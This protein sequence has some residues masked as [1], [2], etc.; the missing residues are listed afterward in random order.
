MSSLPV[1]T[2]RPSGLKATAMT[3]PSC[4]R[5]VPSGLARRPRP[6]A[7]PSCPRCRS[8]MIRPSGLN[9]TAPTRLAMRRGGPTGSPVAASQSRAV[10]SSLPV[11]TRSPSGLK[12]TALTRS[13]CR[14]GGP[15]GA[16]VAASQSRA[17]WSRLPVRT[18]RPSGLKAIASTDSSW[19]R[20]APIG[21]PVA[22]VPEP[23]R[24]VLAR[25]EDGPAVGAEG[26]ARM[27]PSCAREQARRWPWR[28]PRAGPSGRS[29]R[30]ATVRP[31]GLKAT[32]E[33]VCW[34][35]RGGPTGWP[36]GDVPEPGGPVVRC[37]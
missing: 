5:G 32:A 33:T 20:G 15:M 6:R 10:P 18:V 36:V 1:R 4:R 12:A 31:S 30:S 8:A 29:R 23:R 7:G 28:R 19:T 3:R 25:G 9:A 22:G 37:R 27:K 21:A 13:S 17:V 11:R 24:V 14:R 16:P 26:T 2:V 35:R 34:W